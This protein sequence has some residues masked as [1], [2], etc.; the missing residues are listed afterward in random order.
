MMRM[1]SEEP[2]ESE[3]DKKNDEWMKQNYIDLIAEYPNR[4]I[5]VVDQKV[6]ASGN[7]KFLVES[8]TRKLA[9]ERPYSMYFIEPSDIMP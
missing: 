2:V 1:D 5:G 6:V 3:G 7:M 9:N 4:W 8:K